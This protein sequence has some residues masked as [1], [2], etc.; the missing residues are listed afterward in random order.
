MTLNSHQLSHLP[1]RLTSR[2]SRRHAR[3]RRRVTLQLPAGVCG[4]G[5]AQPSAA[6]SGTSG[7]DAPDP[8]GSLGVLHALSVPVS[9]ADLITW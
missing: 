9:R 4:S 1:E 2:S 8:L 7:E 5:P 3:G 6:A